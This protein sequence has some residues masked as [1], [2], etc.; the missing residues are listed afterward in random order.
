MAA[1]GETR[2][3]RSERR[4]EVGLGNAEAA[5]C[6]KAGWDQEMEV[7]ATLDRHGRIRCDEMRNG[8]ADEDGLVKDG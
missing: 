6:D 2:A 7:E 1:L 8:V 3:A 5:C 4:R